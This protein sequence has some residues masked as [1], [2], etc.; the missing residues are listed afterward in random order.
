[1]RIPPKWQ[2]SLPDRMF[3]FRQLEYIVRAWRKHLNA[4]GQSGLLPYPIRI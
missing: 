2:H 4:T 1:M 3:T